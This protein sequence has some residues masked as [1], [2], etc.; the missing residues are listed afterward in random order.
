MSNRW[1]LHSD[2]YPA[3]SAAVANAA[4]FCGVAHA[5]ETGAPNP[6]SILLTLKGWRDMERPRSINGGRA[7]QQRLGERG[8]C[9][10]RRVFRAAP[11]QSYSRAAVPVVVHDRP[12]VD[13]LGLEADPRPSGPQADPVIE[14]HSVAQ[15]R[16]DDSAGCED[17]VS[18][19][20]IWLAPPVAGFL[21]SAEHDRVIVREH[22]REVAFAANADEELG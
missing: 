11:R 12:V 15:F 21:G 22:V 5:P 2:E 7:G 6:M 20:R 1:K 3:D 4:R 14:H 18:G 8:E 19:G 13:L 17:A 10:G 9:D 16:P